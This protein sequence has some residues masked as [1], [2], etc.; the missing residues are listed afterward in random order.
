MCDSEQQR[1]NNVINNIDRLYVTLVFLLVII[2]T[3][4]IYIL[5]N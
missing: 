4:I 2:Y 3:K 5:E 1:K